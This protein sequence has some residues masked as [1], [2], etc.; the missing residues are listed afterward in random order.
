MLRPQLGDD[1]D[2]SSGAQSPID[3]DRVAASLARN[4]S[5]M[6]RMRLEQEMALRDNYQDTDMEAVARRRREHEEEEE[7]IRQAIAD[8][9]AMH[10]QEQQPIEEDMMAE[11]SDSSPEHRYIPIRSGTAH[12]VY[13]D[14][15]TELQAALRAS[16]EDV[17]EGYQ[18]P[19]SPPPP[20]LLYHKEE[21]PE[22]EETVG[23]A[24]SGTDAEDSEMESETSVVA[25][26]QEEMSMEEM[27]KRR[28]ARFET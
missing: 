10:R 13:D 20:P 14:E 24:P 7:M 1:S 21:M 3:D 6:E 17:P 4:R 2:P 8:S 19:H 9:E 12:R 27:R 23:D 16:L 28:L 15:D 18:L 25:P 22:S 26:S 11:D 5:I